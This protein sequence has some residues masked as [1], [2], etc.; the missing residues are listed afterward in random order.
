MSR[1]VSR[2]SAGEYQGGWTRGAQLSARPSDPTVGASVPP[3]APAWPHLCSPFVSCPHE[4]LLKL[5]PGEVRQAGR[6][7]AAKAWAGGMENDTPVPPGHPRVAE[8]HAPDTGPQITC[9][10]HSGPEEGRA[11]R[12]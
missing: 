10:G 9:P 1:Q 6:Q 2:G 4:H 7:S 5:L 12:A 3:A 11:P 8:P